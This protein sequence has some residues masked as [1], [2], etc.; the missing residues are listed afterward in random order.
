MFIHVPISAEQNTSVKGV[1]KLS[2]YKDLKVEINRVWGM[3]T[4]TTLVSGIS[5]PRLVKK[6]LDK[7]ANSI[8]GNNNIWEV[9]KITLLRTSHKL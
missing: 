7:F 4:E 3:M 2:K 6:A 5:A 8:L 1:E 9:Q